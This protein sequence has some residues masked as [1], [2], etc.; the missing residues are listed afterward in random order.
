LQS[1]KIPEAWQAIVV[2]SAMYNSP[3]QH[4]LPLPRG[5]VDSRSPRKSVSLLCR[6][7]ELAA[8]DAG[9]DGHGIVARENSTASRNGTGHRAC[10]RPDPVCG[11]GIGTGGFLP[12]GSVPAVS[13][14]FGGADYRVRDE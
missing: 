2:A 14:H 5:A 8:T 12:G 13:Y 7:R 6:F 3:S 10:D 1:W 9:L 11:S 4:E